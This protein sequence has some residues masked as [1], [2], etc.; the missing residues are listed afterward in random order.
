MNSLNESLRSSQMGIPLDMLTSEYTMIMA[1]IQIK[2]SIPTVFDYSVETNST[3]QFYFLDYT[4]SIQLA[5]NSW[6]CIYGENFDL[7]AASFKVFHNGKYFECVSKIIW[8][9]SLQ[10]N[11]F[12]I[13]VHGR[14]L[15]GRK[16]VQAKNGMSA[17]EIWHLYSAWNKPI[18]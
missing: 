2:D 6:M 9:S 5:Q 1:I 11:I 18:E 3:R 12:T 10:D 16:E 15:S 13:L 8:T 17:N 14:N 4:G 7:Y